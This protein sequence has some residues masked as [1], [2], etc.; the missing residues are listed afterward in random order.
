M[1]RR[2]F[3]R[4][5]GGALLV[6]PLGSVLVQA[7]TGT[8]EPDGSGPAA[9]PTTSGANAEYTS[10][11]DDG[12]AHTFDIAL[13]AF[14][15]PTDIEGQTSV[16]DGHDHAVSISSADLQRVASGQTVMVTTATSEGHTHVLTLVKVD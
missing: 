1:N 4:T 2:G 7:C 6:L 3:F 5:T 10:N 12:H 13:T 15:A 16:D 9:P 11:I 14:S 8:N